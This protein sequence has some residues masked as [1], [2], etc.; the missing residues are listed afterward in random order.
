MYNVQHGN[1]RRNHI[2]SQM[3]CLKYVLY[4]QSKK[5][6]LIITYNKNNS[7]KTPQ[8]GKKNQSKNT[9]SSSRSKEILRQLSPHI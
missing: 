2:C 3:K 7:C 5:N 4:H 9:K 1:A 6:C 8:I